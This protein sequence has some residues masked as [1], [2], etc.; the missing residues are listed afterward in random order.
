MSGPLVVEA[1]PKGFER[2]AFGYFNYTVDHEPHDLSAAQVRLAMDMEMAKQDYARMLGQFS[3]PAPVVRKAP[4]LAQLTECRL[5]HLQ[6][7]LTIWVLAIIAALVLIE[8][9]TRVFRSA[10]HF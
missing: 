3:R 2:Y 7:R 8:P 4:M 10:G 9:L 5:V 6:T 1:D